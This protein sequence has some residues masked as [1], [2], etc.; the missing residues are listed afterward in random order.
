MNER[1]ETTT[2]HA[3]IACYG[4]GAELAPAKVT[5]IDVKQVK[6]AGIYPHCRTCAANH[7]AKRALGGTFVAISETPNRKARRTQAVTPVAQAVKPRRATRGERRAAKKEQAAKAG[8][9]V[10]A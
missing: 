10:A 2:A 6:A 4:C 1:T 8:K 9:Q 3:T 5:W 7:R